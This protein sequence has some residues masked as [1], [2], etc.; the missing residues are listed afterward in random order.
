VPFIAC[1]NNVKTTH[2][3][4]HALLDPLEANQR[5]PDPPHNQGMS[6]QTLHTPQPVRKQVTA[7]RSLHTHHTPPTRHHTR[8]IAC[9]EDA[10]VHYA[11]L[12][13]QP[14]QPPPPPTNGR[15]ERREEQKPNHTPTPLP[16]Q[17]M[18][19]DPSGPNSVLDP[20]PTN[21]GHE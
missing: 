18:T 12:K 13:Q 6:R 11:D 10:R 16:G 7:R 8:S 17:A 20:T 1:L 3:L 14:H 9:S 4:Q 19:A 21:A 15:H 2:A 5:T